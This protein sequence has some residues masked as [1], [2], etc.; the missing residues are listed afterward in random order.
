VIVFIG[1]GAVAASNSEGFL[2]FSVFPAAADGALPNHDAS[3]RAYPP[4]CAPILV[5]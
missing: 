4:L 3:P 1:I 2:I 5:G